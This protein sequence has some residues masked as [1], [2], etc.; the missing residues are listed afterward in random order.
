MREQMV[1]YSFKGWWHPVQCKKFSRGWFGYRWIGTARMNTNANV[2][3]IGTIHTTW[4]Y[5]TLSIYLMEINKTWLMDILSTVQLS[6]KC[7]F[8]I[9]MMMYITWETSAQSSSVCLHDQR[10]L[11]NLKL[12]KKYLQ[13]RRKNKGLFYKI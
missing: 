6:W 5:G 4:K 13:L 10:K 2:Y 12:I 11:L 9:F 7:I 8:C 3:K 1:W